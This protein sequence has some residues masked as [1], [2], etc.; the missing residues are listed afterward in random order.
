LYTPKESYVALSWLFSILITANGFANVIFSISNRNYLKGWGWYLAGGILELIFGILLIAYPNMTMVVF[1]IF[2]GFWL[3]FKGVQTIGASLEL[4]EYGI[5]NWGWLM[6]L[7]VIVT[8]FA[9]FMVLFPVFG[10]HNIVYLASL[11]I[12]FLGASNISLS[13]HLK[14]IKSKTIDKVDA[15]KKEVKNEFKTL[16]ADVVEAYDNASD[17]DKK[18][19]DAAFDTYESIFTDK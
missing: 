11:S 9:T 15:F 16:K 1:P 4:K 3:L 12:F 7:G 5:L 2:T 13:L 10:Y 17:E 14:R 18:Q 6:L 19:I 8:A